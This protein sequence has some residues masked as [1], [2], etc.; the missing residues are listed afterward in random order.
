MDPRDAR[1]GGGRR[2]RARAAVPTF[3]DG[4]PD[5]TFDL[6]VRK[7]LATSSGDVRDAPPPDGGTELVDI[8]RA[9]ARD[10]TSRRW[11]R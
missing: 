6:W 11:W 10:E 9:R 1:G 8:D 2:R 4:I 3:P 7:V 5:D